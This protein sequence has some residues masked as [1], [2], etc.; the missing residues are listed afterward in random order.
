[1][2]RRIYWWNNFT[3]QFEAAIMIVSAPITLLVALWGMTSARTRDVCMS[4][5]TS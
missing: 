2:W 4:A 3:P 1:M 5:F